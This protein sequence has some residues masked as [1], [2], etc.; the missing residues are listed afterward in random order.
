[1]AKANIE[2]LMRLADRGWPLPFAAVANRRSFVEVGD[3]ARLLVDCATHPLA[4]GAIL[5]AA[6]AEAFSTS[7]LVGALRRHLGRP[8]RLFPAPRVLLETAA[9]IA[10]QGERMRRL[11]R[12]LELDVSATEARVGWKASIGLDEAAAAMTRSWRSGWS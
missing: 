6:H 2:S 7:E 11:T 4:V 5:N 3:L 8:P 1:G 10:G 12:S 9:A